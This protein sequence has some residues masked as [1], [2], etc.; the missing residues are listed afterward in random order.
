MEDTIDTITDEPPKVYVTADEL[1]SGEVTLEED[2]VEFAPGKWVRVREITRNELNACAGNGKKSN[3]QIE[4]EILVTA[5]VEPRMTIEQ[6]KR[7]SRRHGAG[8][9][10][11]IA[12]KIRDMSGLG[13]GAEDEAA[14]QFPD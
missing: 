5:M 8:K 13:E 7:F 6:I 10:G 3:L 14:E 12:D 4:Q 9:V 1:S 2:D 11:K